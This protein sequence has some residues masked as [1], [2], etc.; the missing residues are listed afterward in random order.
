MGLKKKE[1]DE[2]NRETLENM[3]NPILM[4]KVERVG[5]DPIRKLKKQDRLTGPALLCKD[6]GVFPY[7]LT[8][9]IANG[10]LF[11][12]ES[13]KNAT[14]VK[15][16]TEYYGIKAAAQKYCQLDD[17]P[18]LIGMIAEHYHRFQNGKLDEDRKIELMKNA[19]H[20]GFKSEK[21][22]KGCAQ[23]LLIAMFELTEESNDMLFQSA[24]GFSGGMAITGDGVCGGYA[25]GVMYMGSV[26]GRRMKEMK[27]DGDKKTQY[28]SYVMAQEL[29]DKYIETYDTVICCDIHEA[30]FGK[31]YC[32]RTKAVRD[33]FEEAGA[34]TNKCTTV[35]GMATAWT[36]A[37]M[38]DHKYIK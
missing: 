37:I 10:F 36:T 20:L 17:E 4:D 16:Y 1:M 7:Y 3:A 11:G 30:V 2:W 19:Y 15:E 33:E 6:N 25:G 28:T 12:N 22:Y 24:S 14:I 31:C 34:H 13:D 26:V 38:Y 27:I 35:V 5:A 23:C 32:L 18:E 9:A 8:K 21:V 29:R